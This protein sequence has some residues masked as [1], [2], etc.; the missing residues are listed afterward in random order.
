MDGFY[1]VYGILSDPNSQGMMPSLV[2]LK[3]TV[4]SDNVGYEVVL[5]NRVIDPVLQHLEQKVLGIALECGAAEHGPLDSGLLQMI[6]DLV[7]ENMGGPVTDADDMLTR[8]TINSYK[9]RTTLNNIV[10]P[11]GHLQIGL[12]RHRALL[13]KILA[14]CVGLPCRVV[15]GSHYTGTDDGAVNMIKLDNER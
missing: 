8:W 1:D 12:S 5:V 10:L 13:F 15:K 2:D 3:R 11:L 6:A 7:A 9:L 4:V 14:D